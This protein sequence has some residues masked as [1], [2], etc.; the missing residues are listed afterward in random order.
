MR[1]L[2]K[3]SGAVCLLQMHPKD[4]KNKNRHLSFLWKDQ[5]I[6]QILPCLQNAVFAG[7]IAAARYE[8]G[9]VKEMVHH[10][11]YSGMTSLSLELGELII[12]RLLR[13][14]F[15]GSLVIVPVP[16]YKKRIY[17]RL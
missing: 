15:K 13:E 6:K 7:I 17:Q 5:P 1:R 4:R 14:P 12:E 9:P 3:T 11:K 2:W 8:A 16:L 10:L